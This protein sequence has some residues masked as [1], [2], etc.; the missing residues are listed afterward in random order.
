VLNLCTIPRIPVQ[1]ISSMTA[2]S[3]S[4]LEVLEERNTK[5]PKRQSR[6]VQRLLE[7]AGPDRPDTKIF[8][9]SG[10]R[11]T[12]SRSAEFNTETTPTGLRRPRRLS[13]PKDCSEK[14][15]ETEDTESE[16]ST[17]GRPNIS[18]GSEATNKLLIRQSGERH[19]LP[20]VSPSSPDAHQAAKIT[21]NDPNILPCF[22]SSTR[23]EEVETANG[24][25]YGYQQESRK[26]SSEANLVISNGPRRTEAKLRSQEPG[27]CRATAPQSSPAPL[28]YTQQP[29]QPVSLSQSQPLERNRIEVG[30]QGSH[31]PITATSSSC[32]SLNRNKMGNPQR[33]SRREPSH[34]EASW[35]IRCICGAREEGNDDREAW[36]GCDECGNWQHN[37]CMG[38]SIY[39]EEIP[40]KYKCE[41]CAP[42]AHKELLDGM[43]RGERPWE[44]RRR[45][46]DLANE[47]NP[48]KKR[49]EKD[50]NPSPASG[51]HEI[52]DVS[53]ETTRNS[54]PFPLTGQCHHYVRRS[55]VDWDIQK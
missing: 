17:K 2:R 6:E 33:Y 11:R 21:K 31:I 39:T 53:A 24:G 47:T 51:D 3:T 29:V 7:T 46:H 4:D 43:D 26:K 30:L 32:T 36:I 25:S 20:S 10:G 1:H 35:K 45:D 44:K 5:R 40:R 37:V 52:A 42:E 9:D 55:D 18:P 28:E 50:G 13:G 38:V 48:N 8:E 12:R 54:K 14:P 49:K 34:E 22:G 15:S 41:D 19:A 27:Q 23:G 16:A